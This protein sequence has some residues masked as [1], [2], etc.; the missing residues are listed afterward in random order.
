MYHNWLQRCVLRYVRRS[1]CVTTERERGEEVVIS[2]ALSFG[3]MVGLADERTT[4]TFLPFY[5][6]L[7]PKSG[8]RACQFA[9]SKM[10]SKYS[11][12]LPGLRRGNEKK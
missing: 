10:C 3:V 12:H 9:R 2:L 7:S 1:Q 11:Y 8:K 5:L 4:T 6:G